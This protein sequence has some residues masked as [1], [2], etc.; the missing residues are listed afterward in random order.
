MR[1]L[2]TKRFITLDS[3]RIRWAP[4]CDHAFSDHSGCSTDDSRRGL[5]VTIR[6]IAILLLLRRT[7]SNINRL[8]GK[9]SMNKL[10]TFATSRF[11]AL[12]EAEKICLGLLELFFLRFVK[13]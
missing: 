9:P 8:S 3:D 6:V 10:T 13:A 5:L 4:F 12:E 7:A 1:V 2:L 11:R